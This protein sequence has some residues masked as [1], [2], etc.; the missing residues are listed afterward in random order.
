MDDD[1]MKLGLLLE[2]AHEHQRLAQGVLEKLKVHV[3][4]LP[5]LARDEI[6]A[7]MLDEL[8]ALQED[9]RRAAETLRRLRYV[10]DLRVAL[11]TLVMT[12]LACAV[13]LG[14]AWWVLPSRAE[15]ASLN[16]RR[17]A[18]EAAVTRLKAQGG[19]LE[20]RHCGA[21]QRLCVRVD[22][23]AGAFGESGDFLIVKGD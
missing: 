9:S 8:N 1:A 3:G 10:A 20:W 13:P 4:E 14:A 16:A 5:G 6:R 22:R 12:A 15:V 2:G 19:E 7:T 23:K 17:D 18:L 11:W 21:A